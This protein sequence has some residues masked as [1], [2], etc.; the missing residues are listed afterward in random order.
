MA[1]KARRVVRELFQLFLAEP[2]CLP[3]EWA[4]LARRERSRTGAARRRLSRRHDR[5]VCPRRASPVVRHLRTGIKPRHDQ[6]FRRFSPA[7]DR[8]ARRIGGS[9]R[10]A[11]RARFRPG[12]GRAAARP[13]AWRSRDQ[14][15]DGAGRPREAEPDGA[16]RAYRHRIVRAHAGERRLHRQRLYRDGATARFYQRPARRGRV[17][18]AAARDPARRNRLWRHRSRPRRAG[19]C[20]VRIGQSDRPDACRSRPRR[21]RRRCARRAAGE[22][23]VRGAS[24]ILHQRRRGAGRCA[25]ALAIPALPRGAR[26]DGRPDPGGVLSRRIPGRDRTRTGRARRRQMARPS[27]GRVAG[28]GARL[29]GCRDAAADPL[30]SRRARGRFRRLR[31]G[32]RT[33]RERRGRRGAGRAV[34]A[35][36]DLPGRA[37]T[38]EG[39]AARRLGAAPADP[40]PRDAIRRRGGPPAQEI[41][42]LLDLFRGRHR[43]SPRQGAPRLSQPDRCL[44]RRSR[45]LRQA[46]AGRRQG[47]ERGERGRSTSS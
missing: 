30:R 26:R 13:G 39:Q 46:H 17:A 4:V 25:G 18:R 11:F 23:R 8:G 32:A 33:G 21:R 19:Q 5:P 22:G 7:R 27:R 2:E 44:G 41:G 29:R 37:R 9:R 35:R 43:L 6:H 34:R 38:A 40:V 36:A 24:R 31:L 10:L 28:A 16:R 45:R 42:R 15:G 3:C 47:A 14:R 20:R 12:R 1:S